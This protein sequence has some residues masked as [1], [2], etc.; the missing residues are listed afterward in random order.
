MLV[1]WQQSTYA[2]ELLVVLCRLGGSRA[3]KTLTF[4]R[5]SQIDVWCG[6]LSVWSC[7]GWASFSACVLSPYISSG[8]LPIS[9][10]DARVFVV[11]F[12]GKEQVCTPLPFPSSSTKPWKWGR[13]GMGVSDLL[14]MLPVCL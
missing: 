14:P 5:P 13:R 3:G 1:V 8:I 2:T 7:S 4:S 11:S 9:S 10:P 6:C 12:S